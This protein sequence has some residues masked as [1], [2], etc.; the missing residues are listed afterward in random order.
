MR[1]GAR[2]S[3]TAPYRQ[4]SSHVHVVVYSREGN[5]GST[6][7]TL[8]AAGLALMVVCA[9]GAGTRIHQGFLTGQQYLDA[10]VSVRRGYAMGILDGLFISPLAGASSE[11]LMSLG[12]CV[13]NMNDDQIEAIFSK[14]LR[15]H[16]ERWHQSAHGAFFGAML[17][18]CEGF[19]P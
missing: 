18:I 11:R 15:E 4:P 9:H 7:R 14:Y 17:D 1:G 2:T 13:E 8:S 10:D 6:L 16:L 5:G 3:L 19:N 12:D